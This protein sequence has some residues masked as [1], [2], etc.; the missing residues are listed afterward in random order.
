MP[1]FLFRLLPP[2]PDFPATMTG[3]ERST[4]DDHV[5][6]WTGLAMPALATPAG[7]LDAG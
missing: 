1:P 5:A 3:A 4:L 2:R 6:Y 7:R